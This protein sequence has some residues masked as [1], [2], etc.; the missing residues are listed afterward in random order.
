MYVNNNQYMAAPFSHI[1]SDNLESSGTTYPVA[2]FTPPLTE[3]EDVVNTNAKFSHNFH[4][5]YAF[6]WRKIDMRFVNKL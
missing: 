3:T 5:F 6:Q 2:Q 4:D 1:H